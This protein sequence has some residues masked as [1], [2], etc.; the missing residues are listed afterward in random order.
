MSFL[1]SCIDKVTDKDIN[2]ILSIIDVEFSYVSFT[3]DLIK[4]KLND[5]KFFLIKYHQK[6]ILIGFLEVEF[7]SNTTAR[8][9]AIFIS[10]SFRGQG[11]ADEL[12]K[13]AIRECKRKRIKK[14]FLLVKESNYGAKKLYEKNKFSFSKLH[15]KEL[16]DSVIEVWEREF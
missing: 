6:N 14:I 7:I 16:D 5:D 4:Q 9:N 10:D 11:F 13:M 8:L 15:D 2:D 12:L 3:Y 1:N